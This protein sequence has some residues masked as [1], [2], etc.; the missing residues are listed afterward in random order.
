DLRETAMT[1]E[2]L[3]GFWAAALALALSACGGG[4]SESGRSNLGAT[5]SGEATAAVTGTITGFGSIYVNGIR[6][7][8]RGATITKDN[9]PAQESDLRVGQ[10]V[11]VRGRIDNR[12]GGTAESITQSDNVKGPIASIDGAASR[13]VVLGQ[14]VIVDANTSFDDSIIPASIQGL[15]VGDQVEVSGLIAANGDIHA[16]RIERRR[17]GQTELK[18]VG[19]VSAH[20]A[21]DKTFKINALTVTYAT[22]QLEGFALGAPADGDL[23]E[24]KGN[25]LN[26][27]GQLVATKVEI[28]RDEP[29][30][31]ERG[32]KREIEGLITRFV[33]A[34][35]FDVA[36]RKVTTN[37]AT[38]FEGGTVADLALNVRVEV[39]GRLD[40]AG[41]LVAAKVS[42]RHAGNA[43]LEARVDSVERA[44]RKLVVL[45][46]EVML[47][48]TTRLEDKGSNRLDRFNIE[49]IQP[50]DFVRVRGRET[51][52][53][54]LTASRLERRN[55]QNEVRVRGT[56]RDVAAPRLTVLG[57]PVETTP[58]TRFEGAGGVSVS[59]A[60]FFAN[61]AGRIVSAK[62]TLSGNVVIAREVEFED[63]DD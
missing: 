29:R 61:A 32:D 20:N 31:A 57:V 23:V 53:L 9:A 1:T 39:E 52:P 49:N 5:L 21:A 40:A 54:R 43:R 28:E 10:V 38:V 41:V 45:G 13:F 16:T 7:E 55:P 24:V 12:G 56:A 6:F 33:S 59:A 51:A 2:M 36:G 14:T 47:T 48:D 19:R 60:E 27:A 30:G 62:G 34:T 37:A 44:A 46:V 8:T 22:A 50:G 18:V 11:N 15:R 35:D 4:G 58:N 42:F 26:A 17:L 3:R 25:T 63:S